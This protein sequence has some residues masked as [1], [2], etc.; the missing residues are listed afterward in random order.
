MS[1]NKALGEFPEKILELITKFIDR[2]DIKGM[3]LPGFFLCIVLNF[4][5]PTLLDGAVFIEWQTFLIFL[6]ICYVVGIAIH[7]I[8]NR[9]EKNIVEDWFKA[10][11]KDLKYIKE[12]AGEDRAEELLKYYQQKS[13]ETITN[14]KWH[15]IVRKMKSDEVD[16]WME[17]KIKIY[18]GFN[19]TNRGLFTAS[20]TIIIFHFVKYGNDINFSHWQLFIFPIAILFCSFAFF[21]SMRKYEIRE[22]QTLYENV[23]LKR[24]KS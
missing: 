1:E 4:Y 11:L 20:L 15:E 12:I 19:K 22:L 2:H 9:I 5:Y 21:T 7:E 23:N 10:D 14:K 17:D 3:F 8:G 13:K 16:F 24:H 6:A 18:N